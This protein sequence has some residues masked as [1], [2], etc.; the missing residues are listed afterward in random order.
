MKLPNLDEAHVP[1]AKITDYLLN[2][3]HP[4]GRSKANFF[5]QF[6]F[7]VA[8]W[9]QLADALL[10]HARNH[11]VAKTEETLFGTRYVIEG[12][13]VTPDQRMP[14]ARVVWFIEKDGTQPRLVTA[15]PLEEEHD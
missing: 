14:Q 10:T 6:G 8:Q 4:S 11:P 7:S 5:I 2:T 1:K 3:Q 9:K 15:Y 13:L 12:D